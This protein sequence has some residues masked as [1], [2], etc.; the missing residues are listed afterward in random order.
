MVHNDALLITLFEYRKKTLRDSSVCEFESLWDLCWTLRSCKDARNWEGSIIIVMGNICFTACTWKVQVILFIV[1]SCM[2][3]R[4][5]S[6]YSCC[7]A[8][9]NNSTKVTFKGHKCKHSTA[10]MKLC[11]KPGPLWIHV[12][13]TYMFC[14]I[15]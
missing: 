12:H 6:E 9:L 7:I 1:S 8:A 14:S 10:I 2:V 5:K 4:W 13:C 11:L 3:A 15:F